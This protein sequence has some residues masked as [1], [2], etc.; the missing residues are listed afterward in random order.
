MIG[1]PKEYDAKNKDLEDLQELNPP[2]PKPIKKKDGDPM[3][4]AFGQE[5]DEEE[6]DEEEVKAKS[7]HDFIEII[8]KIGK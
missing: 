4:K 2:L 7:L 1:T 8:V 5:S 6:E 3:D